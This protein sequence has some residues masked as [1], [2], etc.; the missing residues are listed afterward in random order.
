[1][2]KKRKYVTP[3]ISI[4]SYGSEEY[5][6]IMSGLNQRRLKECSNPSPFDRQEE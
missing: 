2:G 3:S 5:Y 4:I 1:M 6:K